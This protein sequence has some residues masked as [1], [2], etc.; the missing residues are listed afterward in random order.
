MVLGYLLTYL[1]TYLLKY[2][3]YTVGPKLEA[4]YR[5]LSL[6]SSEIIDN[7][8]KT[9]ERHIFETDVKLI[10]IGGRPACNVK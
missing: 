2:L 6:D 5:L 8:R 1:L 9:T 10:I 3:L 4:E 7:H